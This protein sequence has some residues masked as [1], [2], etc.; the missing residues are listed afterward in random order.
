MGWPYEFTT[1]TDEEKQLRRSA[2]DHYAAVAHYS[3]FAPAL[4]YLLVRLVVHVR[5]RRRRGRYQEVPNSPAFKARKLSWSAALAG[6]G[7]MVWWW[8]GDDVYFAGGHWG[9]RDEW[10]FGVVWMGWLL[11]LCVVG[12]G[13]GEFLHQ[14]S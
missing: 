4:A 2:L 7:R 11:A 5:G 3:A 1:L 8:M 9:Q 6:R 10:I 14:V 13:K 12:T